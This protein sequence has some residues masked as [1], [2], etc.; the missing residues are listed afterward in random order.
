MDLLTIDVTEVPGLVTRGAE[1]EIIGPHMTLEDM[2]A[3]A[4]TASYEILTSLGNRF[5]R[6]Y[7]DG[8]FGR[9]G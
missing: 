5:T 3:R 2:A 9:V 4:G 6:I 7:R 8:P 1:V